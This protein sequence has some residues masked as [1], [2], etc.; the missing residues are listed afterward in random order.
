MAA[1]NHAPNTGST[2][3]KSDAPKR[4]TTGHYSNKTPGLPN[5]DPKRADARLRD[6]SGRA[7]APEEMSPASATVRHGW[8]A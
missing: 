8:G 5:T 4:S 3:P 6:F 1:R 7:V 2:K